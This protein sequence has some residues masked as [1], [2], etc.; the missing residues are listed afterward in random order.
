MMSV[1]T[2]SKLQ[3][4]IEKVV[5]SFSYVLDLPR[6]HGQLVSVVDGV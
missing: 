3:E 5:S 2:D 6:F 4:A 1:M